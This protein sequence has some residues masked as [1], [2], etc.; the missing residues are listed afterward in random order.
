MARTCRE[1]IFSRSILWGQGVYILNGYN[2]DLLERLKVPR[3]QGFQLSRVFVKGKGDAPFDG[4]LEFLK[5]SAVLGVETFF[6]AR[7]AST[8]R[9]S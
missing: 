4:R 1:T 6:F 8:S 3:Q 2:L 7:S 9:S 5:I